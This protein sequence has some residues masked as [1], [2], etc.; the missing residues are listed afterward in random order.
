MEQLHSIRS[1]AGPACTRG[2]GDEVIRQFLARDKE[3]AR[4]IGT[5]AANRRKLSSTH[6]K[7]FKMEEKALARLLQRQVLNFYSASGINPYVPLA[8]SGSWIVTSH[9]AVIHD[10]GGYGML[11]MG[12]AP[13]AVLAAMNEPFVMANVMTPSFSQHRLTERLSREIGGRRGSCPFGKFAFLNSG[14][15]SVTFTCR[16]ADIHARTMTDPGGRHAG[17]KVKRLAIMEGFHGRTEGPAR[18][19][20]SCRALYARHLASFRDPDNL[21]FVPIN[22][23]AA[24]RKTFAEAEKN[25][26]F[27]EAFF[28][29][30]VM[31]EGIPGLALTREYYDKARALTRKMGSLLVVDSIQAALRAHGC[32]SIVDY[33]GF[34]TCVPPDMETFSKALNAGQYPL[35]VAALSGALAARYLTGLYGNTMTGNPR[36]MEA[37]CAVLDSVTNKVR[38]NIRERGREFIVKFQALAGEFPG[39]VEQVVGTGLMVSVMLN[40]KRYRV[41]GEGGFEEYMRVNGIEMIHGGEC[42]LRFTPSFSITSAEIDL[43]VSVIR[44]GLKE[45]ASSRTEL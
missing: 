29:E 22:D 10:C 39:A 23:L 34:E 12:H 40:P 30:P 26:V 37:G 16:V 7:W 38:K 36:A 35:S 11:G 15:E 28:V 41:P 13:R 19:S 1:S 20:H 3:L 4:A 24:L 21:L 31:G 25:G 42:G 18:T 44:R 8:A 14:S 9:G 6:K 33:P 17:K 43:I 32:L 2:L 5:A 27:F 45:L